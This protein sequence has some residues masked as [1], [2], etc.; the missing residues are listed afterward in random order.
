MPRSVP[1]SVLIPVRNEQANLPRCLAAV[2]WAEEIIVVD[3]QSTDG[4]VSIAE[5]HGAR[6]EQFHFNG[7]WP[8]KKNWALEN[9]PF[10]HEWV[11]I[12]DADEVMPPTLR[13]EIDAIVRDPQHPCDGYWINRRFQF[14]GQWLRHAYYPNWNLRLF[15]HH[16][17][18][19]E[20][21]TAQPTA[22]GDN[23]VHEQVVV[24]G[25]TGRLRS[26]MDHYAF[27]DVATFVE[28]HN[29][30]SNWEAQ[31]TLSPL[32]PQG[33]QQDHWA[34]WRRRL[35]RLSQHLPFRPTLRFAY[36]YFWERGFLDGRAGYLFARLH[37]YYEFL[38]VAKTEELRRT[39]R[40]PPPDPSGRTERILGLDFFTGPSEDAVAAALQ[41]QLIVAPAGPSL[42]IDLV[43]NA[44]YRRS[45]ESADLV[46]TDSG[47]LLL[48]W[49]R[50]TGR[51]LPRLSGLGYLRALL[52]R[53]EVRAPGAVLWVMP[54]EAQASRQRTWLQQ[55]GLPHD[56]HTC[57]I[58]P[59]Y[60]PH[61]DISD[62]DLVAHLREHRPRLVILAIGGGTQ[63]RLGLH[64]REAL[65]DLSAPPGI[66]CVG[67]AVGFLNGSQTQ[68]P[69]WAD[70]WLLGWLFRVLSDPRRFVKR[71]WRALRLYTV[72]RRWGAQSPPLNP[73]A[74]PL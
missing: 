43:Q 6:V 12:V 54:D 27:P 48:I 36:I 61:G 67:A 60:P 19:Y 57:W 59:M 15:R 44:A 51:R 33:S 26:E 18:R 32:P 7:T 20:Q 21:L 9:V 41:S 45:V 2:A 64:L 53:P 22:S 70:R 50:L 35:K 46:L 47:Y 17:G 42:A 71:Y 65:T 29:R 25:T 37:A 69:A 24:N 40:F 72:V 49:R 8:K 63:E 13:D 10:Q 74:S 14:L 4:T 52:K 68:I 66:V 62:P 5:A 11:L 56:D 58:A 39:Q 3:S 28:K 30:Y 34:G 38:S 55:Q 16:L 1:V 31:A 23:E 73:S